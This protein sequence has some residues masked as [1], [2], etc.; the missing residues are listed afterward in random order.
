MIS[1]GAWR[2]N[3]VESVSIVPHSGVRGS[4][5]PRPEE[6][7]A[8]DVDD[9]RRQGQRR[10]DDQRRQRVREHVAGQQP[11][12]RS[13]RRSEPR[14]RSPTR[15]AR[16]GCR[17]GCGRRSG[18]STIATANMIWGSPRSSQATMPIASRMPGI[19]SMTSTTRIRTASTLPPSAAGE[20]SDR[21]RP[22]STPMTTAVT[23]ATQA[24]L[25]P[26]D[27]PA[28][29]VAA[30]E[31]GTHA[32]ARRSGGWSRSDQRCLRAGRTGA[33]SGASTA[34]RTKIGDEDTA[35]TCAGRLRD[36]RRSGIAPQAAA[37]P[38]L[39]RGGRPGSLVQPSG[40]PDPRVEEG[41]A[42]VHH[43]VHHQEDEGEDQDRATGP[44]SSRGCGSPRRRSVRRHPRRRRSR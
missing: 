23:P 6:A 38:G 26:V 2:R 36:R 12:R 5:G 25:G 22:I 14:S 1:H 32:G 18:R 20:R 27:H 19:A 34:A 10:G 15:A 30:L 17:A 3:F 40:V 39:R 11:R 31:I 43:Q 8:G 41:V 4:G 29:L 28:E 42:D 35:R 7:E 16:A 37:A 13:H 24:D 44:R 21:R 9:R 33:M